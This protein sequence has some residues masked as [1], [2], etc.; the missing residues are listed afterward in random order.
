MISGPMKPSTIPRRCA[1][2]AIVRSSAVGVGPLYGAPFASYPTTGAPA[3]G[4]G[5][6]APSAGGV[7]NGDGSDGGGLLSVIGSSPSPE[8]SRSSGKPFLSLR[9]GRPLEIRRDLLWRVTSPSPAQ[10]RHAPPAAPC[11]P[12]LCR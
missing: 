7:P 4:G 8:S 5:G 1:S 12:A 11:W 3:A 10:T 9:G 2:K 6:A